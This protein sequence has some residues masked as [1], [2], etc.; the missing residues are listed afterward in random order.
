MWENGR[1]DLLGFYSAEEEGPTSP[2]QPDRRPQLTVR[3]LTRTPTMAIPGTDPDGRMWD[4][5]DGVGL[6]G[7]DSDKN[8]TALRIGDYSSGQSYRILLSFDTSVFPDNYTIEK[9]MLK[10]ARG[11]HSGINPFNWGG[12]CYI[13][14]ANPYFY[15]SEQMEPQDWHV[16]ATAGA[17]AT[18]LNAPLDPNE[19]DYM[20]SSGLNAQG[21]M[22]INLNGLTQFRV[23]FTNRNNGSG[24][25]Y[26]GFWPSEA[27]ELRKPKLLIEYSID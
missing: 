19:G 3:Y 16:P 12:T 8:S 21:R 23:R 4:N 10:L 5:G 18:F 25:D 1:T 24:T 11:S 7:R 6:D 27:I 20:I 22:N 2:G 26:L 13:D 17:V 15:L 9:V 14:L